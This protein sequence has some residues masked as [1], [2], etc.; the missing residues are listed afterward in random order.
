MGAG[1]SFFEPMELLDAESA[2][3]LKK[4]A[5]KKDYDPKS[6]WKAPSLTE[7]RARLERREFGAYE[8][9][10]DEMQHVFATY[11]TGLPFKNVLR[12]KAQ[13]VSHFV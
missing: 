5:L 8:Q 7:L 2:Q 11:I 10:W 3:S 4:K 12:M 1:K 9:F 13:S 6:D